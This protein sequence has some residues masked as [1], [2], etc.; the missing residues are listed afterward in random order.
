MQ[1]Y[2]EINYNRHNMSSF[3]LINCKKIDDHTIS[4]DQA[5]HKSN[6]IIKFLH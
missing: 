2:Y 3:S 5:S 1:F 6:K 4:D